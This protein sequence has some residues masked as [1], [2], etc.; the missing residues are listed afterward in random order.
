MAPNRLLTALNL[1][2]TYP[3][4]CCLCWD[5]LS[6]FHLQQM[7]QAQLSYLCWNLISTQMHWQVFGEGVVCVCVCLNTC[8]CTEEGSRTELS[9][10]FLWKL[11]SR[12]V[13]LPAVLSS[14][15]RGKE[16]GARHSPSLT[17]TH[18]LHQDSVSVCVYASILESE[19]GSHNGAPPC[20]HPLWPTMHI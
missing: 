13:C 2:P 10:V 20:P 17:S 8:T 9:F 14:D 12:N 11:R 18:L 7:S 5:Y 3:C 6:D 4:A 19:R 16:G 1:L 15:G